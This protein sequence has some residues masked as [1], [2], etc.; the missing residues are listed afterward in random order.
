MTTTNASGV[1]RVSLPPPPTTPIAPFVNARPEASVSNLLFARLSS[2]GQ[3]TI[4]SLAAAVDVVVD[5]YGYFGLVQNQGGVVR[6]AREDNGLRISMIV[7]EH[8]EVYLSGQGLIWSEPVQSDPAVL[9]RDSA[10]Q[11]ADGTAT[12]FFTIIGQGSS[13][14]SATGRVPCASSSGSPCPS[15]VYGFGL[16]IDA[17]SAPLP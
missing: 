2:D 16:H 6:A 12:G 5:L 9:R 3:L 8:L 4:E 10:T 7:G 1:T 17:D 11:R 15:P 14:V 13:D